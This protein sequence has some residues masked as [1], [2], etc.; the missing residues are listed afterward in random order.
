MFSIQL[1]CKLW[2]PL[3]IWQEP[4]ADFVNIIPNQSR[5]NNI[6]TTQRGIILIKTLI[7]TGTTLVKA[8]RGQLNPY[9]QM[10][11]EVLY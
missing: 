1:H 11:W 9:S 8:T 3:T 5:R 6:R 2:S 4:K 7:K 10:E